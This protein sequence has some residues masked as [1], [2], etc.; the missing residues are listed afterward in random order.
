MS[1]DRQER[2]AAYVDVVAGVIGHADR[3]EPLRDYCPC[4]Y[5]RE[6]LGKRN[7]AFPQSIEMI[8]VPYRIRTGVAA[9]R[10]RCPGPLDEGDV[11][12]QR[13]AAA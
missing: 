10:G 12:L 11:G 4:P 1:E 7:R 3:A 9:V 8:G 6:K 13:R 5:I 2:F